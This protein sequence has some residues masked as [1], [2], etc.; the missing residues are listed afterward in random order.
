MW[1][2]GG[3]HK[4]CNSK[5]ER[6]N[7][8]LET[9]V[10]SLEEIKG[11]EFLPTKGKKKEVEQVQR[12]SQLAKI[13]IR[14]NARFWNFGLK[15]S[16]WCNFA[17][18]LIQCYQELVPKQILSVNDRE[19]TWRWTSEPQVECP[20]CW[21]IKYFVIFPQMSCDRS[22]S[23]ASEDSEDAM[24]RHQFFSAGT[25]IVINF[26]QKFLEAP[27]GRTLKLESVRYIPKNEKL[28][29]HNLQIDCKLQKNRK[30]SSKT[31]KAIQTFGRFRR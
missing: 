11:G 10:S 25:Q 7:G 1:I 8:I 27:W 3:V 20:F 26:F 5:S 4:S 12:N 19:N 9:L 17:G 22:F 13:I 24:L 30:N 2:K 16:F 15:R 31:H 18:L 29:F 14:R 28:F 23:E 6:L 21:E